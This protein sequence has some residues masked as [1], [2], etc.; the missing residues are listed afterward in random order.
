MHTLM[1]WVY[2]L[3]VDCAIPWSADSSLRTMD[4]A[5]GSVKGWFAC[6]KS[7]SI[8]WCS[9]SGTVWSR[10]KRVSVLLD[11]ELNMLLKYLAELWYEQSKLLLKIDQLRGCCNA[12]EKDAKC[13]DRTAAILTPCRYSWFIKYSAEHRDFCSLETEVRKALVIPEGIQVEEAGLHV[14]SS[15]SWPQIRSTLLCQVTAQLSELWLHR[16]QARRRRGGARSRLYGVS[17]ISR[18][19]C[20]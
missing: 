4:E 8:R 2:Y 12:I 1:P 20:L 16:G 9:T 19:K 18:S 10:F 3:L 17:G 14:P 15:Y 6:T 11:A 7:R 13:G 5:D